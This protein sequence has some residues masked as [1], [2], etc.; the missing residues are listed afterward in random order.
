MA[1]DAKTSR[2]S[3][4]R[5]RQAED[6]QPV[7]AQSPSGPARGGLQDRQQPKAGG[8]DPGASRWG[9]NQ[10][11]SRGPCAFGATPRMTTTNCC[12]SRH[13]MPRRDRHRGQQRLLDAR[14]LVVGAG[15]L[16]SPVALYLA[17]A[18]V[19]HITW[20]TTTG[21]LADQPATPDRPR[22]GAS[23]NRAKVASAARRML[24]LNPDMRSIRP[25]EQR[26][27]AALLDASGPRPTSWWTAPTTSPRANS[28]TRRLRAPRQTAGVRRG[29]RL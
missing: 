22:P 21:D 8:Q 12:Y 17:S 3:P 27:D 13:L 10:G 29:D 4:A 24:A 9:P 1:K 6:F 26:A 23:L 11:R 20:W 15:G 14:V 7:Q 16:G 5:V 25:I 18:G 2:P 28:S 19:G